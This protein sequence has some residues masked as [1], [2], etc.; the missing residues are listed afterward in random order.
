MNVRRLQIIIDTQDEYISQL[1]EDLAEAHRHL[2]AFWSGKYQ[3]GA[4]FSEV[5]LAKWGKKRLESKYP[6]ATKEE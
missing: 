6:E 5:L 2:D 3:E 4:T 1:E